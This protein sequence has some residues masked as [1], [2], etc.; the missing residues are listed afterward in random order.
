MAQPGGSNQ[1]AAPEGALLRLSVEAIEA[2]YNTAAS[3]AVEFSVIAD[4]EALPSLHVFCTF[5]GK[6]YETGPLSSWSDT[7][8]SVAACTGTSSVLIAG[9]PDHAQNDSTDDCCQWA[10]VK[11]ELILAP[12]SLPATSCEQFIK[13]SIAFTVVRTTE[14][15]ADVAQRKEAQTKISRSEGKER[16]GR[17]GGASRSAIPSGESRIAEMSVAPLL[18]LKDGERAQPPEGVQETLV[19]VPG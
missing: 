17:K 14:S 1:A 6:V 15:S 2:P 9:S 7:A 8:Q 18:L 12:F 4:K 3:I 13:E 16:V 5:L 11:Y 10:A 19:R